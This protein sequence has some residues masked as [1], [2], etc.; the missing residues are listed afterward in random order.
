MGKLLLNL[1]F[2]ENRLC[3]CVGA[4]W[5]S[6][7]WSTVSTFDAKYVGMSHVGVCMFA[8][9]FTICVAS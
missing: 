2:K 9:T 1:C 6:G 7:H 8:A 3:L 4:R 5:P